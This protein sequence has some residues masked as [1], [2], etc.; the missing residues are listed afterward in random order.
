[1]FPRLT[2]GPRCLTNQAWAAFVGAS[3]MRSPSVE[4]VRELVHEPGAELAGRPE[5]AGSTG[6]PRLGDHLPGAGLQLFP[7]PLHPEVGRKVDGGVLRADL[8][9]DREVAGEL[10]DQL[11]LALARDLDRAVG[12]LD[13][14]EPL[15]DE[16][17]LV[18]VQLP[19]G[20]GDLEQRS[21]ADDGRAERAVERDLLLRLRVTY[22]VPQ[23]SFTMST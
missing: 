18:L 15:L 20:D 19:A 17:A 23:P 5:D 1:M 12:D 3:K 2:S 4:L 13:V 11:E 10:G 8:G 7:A 14:R 6:L 16:P 9:E 21:A 22:E